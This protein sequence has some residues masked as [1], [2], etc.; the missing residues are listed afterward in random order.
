MILQGVG[1]IVV[2]VISF[3]VI[4]NNKKAIKGFKNKKSFSGAGILTAIT[5]KTFFDIDL[6]TVF[7]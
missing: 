6:I 4:I 2:V 1:I 3:K 7:F 5:F